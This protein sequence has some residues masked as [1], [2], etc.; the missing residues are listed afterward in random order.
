MTFEF[1]QGAWLSLLGEKGL[2]AV[3]VRGGMWVILARNC[4]RLKCAASVPHAAGSIECGYDGWVAICRERF[5]RPARKL[6]GTRMLI[7]LLRYQKTTN[8]FE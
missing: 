2:E 4:P 6:W 7:I 3:E 8:H 5:A 1:A